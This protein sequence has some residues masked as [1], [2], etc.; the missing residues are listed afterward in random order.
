MEKEENVY[1]ELCEAEQGKTEGTGE[2]ENRADRGLAAFGKFKDVDALMQAYAALE[3]EFT[4]RSQKLRRLERAMEKFSK[5]AVGSEAEKLRERAKEKR[6]AAKAFDEF[7]KDGVKAV[8]E[9]ER[10]NSVELN[11]GADENAEPCDGEFCSEKGES[12]PT[13]GK[14]ILCA[15][16]EQGLQ[17]GTKEEDADR[18]FVAKSAEETTD[19]DEVYRMVQRNE[20]ARLRVIG[21]YLASLGKTGAPLTTAGAVAMASPPRRISDIG[22]AGKRALELFRKQ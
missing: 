22:D 20:G 19:A 1:E 15:E 11:V 5:E 12:A 2:G 8:R 6:E 14:G 9:E 18:T 13:E 7:L 4:R 17:T 16:T 3:A 21:E 10:E